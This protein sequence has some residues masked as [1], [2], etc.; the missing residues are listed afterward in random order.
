MLKAIDQ[1]VD[2]SFLHECRFLI[3]AISRHNITR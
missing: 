3:C 1:R 2:I